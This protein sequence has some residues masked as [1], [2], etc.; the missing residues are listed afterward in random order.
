MRFGS[1]L[2]PREVWR[3]IRPYW[4]SHES[5]S[6]LIA[7]IVLLAIT[8]ASAGLGAWITGVSKDFYDAIEKRDV[9]MFW[10]TCA[11]LI[12]VFGLMAGVFAFTQWLTQWLEI[13]W[14]TG[15]TD[16]LVGR[17]L[18]DNA[19]YRIERTQLVDNSDQRI[20]E[21]ARLFVEAL[22]ELGL[23]LL[24]NVATL[25]F[26][27]YILWTLASP[28][29]L[30]PVAV[31]GFLFFFAVAFGV[32]R[33]GL[34]HWAG[35]RLAGLTV[36]Q[37]RVEANFRF[38]LA[39]QREA[40]E[41]I[42]LYRG[43]GT[44]KR[45]LTH[46]FASIAGNWRLLMTQFKRVA[47]T[48]QIL[49]LVTG[50][51]PMIVLAPKLFAGEVN[52]GSLMQSQVA[53]IAVAS[54][55]AWFTTYYAK[56]AQWSAVT[57]RLIGLLHALDA[58]EASGVEVRD[59]GRPGVGANG[60]ELELPHGRHLASIG[61]WR[62]ELGER[63]LIKGP[64]GAGKS[65]LL[66]AVAGIWPHGS[67]TISIPPGAR[68]MFLPQKSY[69]PMG[70]LKEALCYPATVDDYDDASCIQALRDCRLPELATR[71]SETA[72]WSQRLSGG[73]QQRLAMARALLAKPDF[74]FLDESTSALD[75]A[76]EDALYSLLSS[77]L[78]E[79][80]VVSIAHHTSLDRF[81]NKVLEVKPDRGTANTLAIAPA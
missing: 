20:S 52:L 8:V 55:I 24:A 47:F 54:A 70:T 2:P 69:I 30:G 19:F 79:T 27:G 6:G 63:W 58:P 39:Q 17:W 42:A 31:P 60:L 38:A 76:T 68:V 10:R 22:L 35:H 81:H 25:V 15:L 36:E 40:A 4:T 59:D 66:R 51:V 71:L 14:R 5:R 49:G 56:L 72:A 50:F 18:G 13:R 29:Q 1:K 67:G 45:R 57:Q 7:L 12:S 74:L 43:A 3:L 26:M 61:N 16:H 62:A 33:V 32:F 23:S 46:L 75:P 37:Q 28:L 11:L 48:N 21:D 73:E 34:V 64:S 77:R 78:P 41:Q 44:E 9:A 80:A 53:F 65:T